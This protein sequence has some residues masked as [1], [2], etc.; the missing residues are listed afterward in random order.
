MSSSDKKVYTRDLRFLDFL[1]SHKA[2]NQCIDVSSGSTAKH[3]HLQNRLWHSSKIEPE[4]ERMVEWNLFHYICLLTWREDTVSTER[5]TSAFMY[6]FLMFASHQKAQVAKQTIRQLAIQRGGRKII[7]FHLKSFRGKR[8][9]YQVTGGFISRLTCFWRPN[10]ERKQSQNNTQLE[11]K[12]QSFCLL[13]YSSGPG[14]KPILDAVPLP[15]RTGCW[16][17]AALS[18]LSQAAANCFPSEGKYAFV[19]MLSSHRYWTQDLF[20]P[21]SNLPSPCKSATFSF[22]SKSQDLVPSEEFYCVWWLQGLWPL[23]IPPGCTTE[24]FIL[25]PLWGRGMKKDHLKKNRTSLFPLMARHL[26]FLKE[27]RFHFLIAW[28]LPGND[29]YML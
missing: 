6:D 4:S 2:E 23:A 25:C 24:M 3:F 12:N 18:A 19:F 7:L 22:I 20:F 9:C 11:K 26:V 8:L 13:G 10:R 28:Q 15:E 5:A 17:R 16:D 21:L 27:H 14:S 29:D 1:F